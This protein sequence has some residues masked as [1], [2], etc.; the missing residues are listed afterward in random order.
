M[1]LII[2]FLARETE[3][4]SVPSSG[5]WKRG[6]TPREYR[7]SV[8]KQHLVVKVTGGCRVMGSNAVIQTVDNGTVTSAVFADRMPEYCYEG[9][10][11]SPQ[12]FRVILTSVHHV[13]V[14]S[15]LSAVLKLVNPMYH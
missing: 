5:R 1:I 11:R 10:T 9:R 12:P 13:V 15:A 14:S 8:L 3:E 7:I 4:V 2:G 6:G